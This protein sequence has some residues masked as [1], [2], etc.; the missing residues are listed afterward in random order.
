VSIGIIAI[1]WGQVRQFLV[2]LELETIDVN[3]VVSLKHSMRRAVFI[4]P[5]PQVGWGY[6]EICAS[7]GG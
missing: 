6:F 1:T 7:G 5:P 2:D 4:L 3:L